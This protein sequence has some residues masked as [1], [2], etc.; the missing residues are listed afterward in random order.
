MFVMIGKNEFKKSL[1]F[2]FLIL[3]LCLPTKTNS[4]LG[5]VI[6]PFVLIAATLGAA[7]VTFVTRHVN[8]KNFISFQN[9]IAFYSITIKTKSGK[10]TESMITYT[11]TNPETVI[12]E[13]MKLIKSQNS[14]SWFSIKPK[15][16]LMT[17]ETYFLGIITK[18][19][20]PRKEHSIKTLENRIEKKLYER[21][22]V[23]I[24][25]NQTYLEKIVGRIAL[26]PLKLFN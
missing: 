20:K 10:K 13:T 22:I 2:F 9:D 8:A 7:G 5:F 6:P 21:F 11:A 18:D 1:F 16:S 26:L 24:C 3:V 15:V 23:P 12:N 14:T 25:P 4:F 17:G 19:K